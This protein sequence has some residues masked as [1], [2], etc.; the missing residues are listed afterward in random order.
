MRK[1]R[2]EMTS[3]FR[4]LID[5]SVVGSLCDNHLHN[6]KY[7]YNSF[8]FPHFLSKTSCPCKPSLSRIPCAWLGRWVVKSRPRQ[9]VDCTLQ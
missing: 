6:A 9:K 1:R 8:V 3:S 2:G 5:G 4:P 7:S